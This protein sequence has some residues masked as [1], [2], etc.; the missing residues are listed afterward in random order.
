MNAIAQYKQVG[1]AIYTFSTPSAFTLVDRVQILSPDAVVKLAVLRRS[2]ALPQSLLCGGVYPGAKL[3]GVLYVLKV[4][5][6]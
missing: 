6:T 3:P 5:V 2:S 4:K 1:Q